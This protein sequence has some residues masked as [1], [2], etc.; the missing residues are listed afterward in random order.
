MGQIF[1]YGKN[2]Y[3]H[4]IS[5][6]ILHK[7]ANFQRILTILFFAPRGQ[8]VGQIFKYAKNR[9]H[10]RIYRAILHKYANFQRILTILS[11]KGNFDPFLTL[12]YPRGGKK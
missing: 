6:E 10:H 11:L 7:Y 2:G 1:K 8:K 3:N 5:R 4:H 9:Y 12:F